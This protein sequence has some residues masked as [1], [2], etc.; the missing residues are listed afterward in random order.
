MAFNTICHVEWW[1][2]D[3]DKAK[4]FYGGLFG[5]TFQDF[6]DNYV[7]FTTPEGGPG[8]GFMKGDVPGVEFSPGNS[9]TVYIWVEEIDDF[10]L[11]A[12]SLGGNLGYPKTEIPG[13]GWSASI[14]D[15]FGNG[16]GLFQSAKPSE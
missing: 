10:I 3:F 4:E 14:N 7:L 11:K 1:V 16:I 9:P 2:K 8:G 5:W 13:M 15:P 12:K 6:G